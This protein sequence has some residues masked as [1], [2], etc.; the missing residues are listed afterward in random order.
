MDDNSENE[1]ELME[2]HLLC[3]VIEDSVRDIREIITSLHLL[4]E[5]I[6]ASNTFFIPA[7]E[8]DY[9]LH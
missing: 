7:E 5:V 9:L 8:P 2:T 1:K 4:N 6:P 3:E